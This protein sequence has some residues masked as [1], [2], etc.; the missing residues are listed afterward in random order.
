MQP[1]PSGLKPGFPSQPLP[2]ELKLVPFKAKVG[3]GAAY[4]VL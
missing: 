3:K 1:I 2:D 4:Q